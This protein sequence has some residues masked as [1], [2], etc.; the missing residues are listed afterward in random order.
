MSG[1]VGDLSPQQAKALQKVCAH[2]IYLS[3]PK[4]EWEAS[5]G[6]QWLLLMPLVVGTFVSLALFTLAL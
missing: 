2:K 1:H 6:T 4:W 5:S 3:M